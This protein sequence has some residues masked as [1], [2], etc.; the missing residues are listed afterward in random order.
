MPRM[1]PPDAPE[2]A[3]K[4]M[5]REAALAE[6]LMMGPG[7]WATLMLTE[8]RTKRDALGKLHGAPAS[9]SLY[10]SS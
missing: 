4:K 2:H 3:V 10:P 7:L 6:P 5:L 9:A 8:R 1:R